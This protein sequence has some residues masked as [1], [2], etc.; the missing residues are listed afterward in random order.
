MGLRRPRP[1]RTGGPLDA[2]D[3]VP[4]AAPARQA[5]AAEGGGGT[6]LARRRHRGAG[7][8]GGVEARAECDLTT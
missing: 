6:A 2:S 7:G 5:G 3:K 1:L 4:G 8:G